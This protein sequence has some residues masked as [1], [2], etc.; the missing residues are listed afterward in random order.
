MS[1]SGPGAVTQRVDGRAQAAGLE[2]G[3]LEVAVPIRD[4]DT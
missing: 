1:R 3:A 2:E 4:E